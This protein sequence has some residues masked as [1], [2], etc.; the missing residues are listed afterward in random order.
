[1]TAD[2]RDLGVTPE[3][4]DSQQALDVLAVRVDEA[5]DRCRRVYSVENRAAFHDAWVAFDRARKAATDLQYD[6]QWLADV[7]AAVGGAL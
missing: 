4:A 6:R 2:L 1:V 3:H 7:D 5:V